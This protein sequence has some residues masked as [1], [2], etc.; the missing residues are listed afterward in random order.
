MGLR[1]VDS[2]CSS[3]ALALRILPVHIYSHTYIHIYIHKCTYVF[4]TVFLLGLCPYGFTYACKM[5]EFAEIARPS[6]QS[7]SFVRFPFI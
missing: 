2:L 7:L 3:A 1:C 6:V 5:C 4:L